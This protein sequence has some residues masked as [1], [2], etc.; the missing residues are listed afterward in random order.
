MAQA[1]IPIAYTATQV[2]ITAGSF[3]AKSGGTIHVVDANGQLTG[4]QYDVG[5]ANVAPTLAVTGGNINTV[6]QSAGGGSYPK[7]Q[8]QGANIAL[9]YAAHNAK[10][11]HVEVATLPA[12]SSLAALVT[13]DW[14]DGT[15]F[16]DA[17]FYIQNHSGAD[18]VFSVSVGT[19]NFAGMAELGNQDV[20]AGFTIPDVTEALVK[21]NS[22]GWVQISIS[23]Q[24]VT[25]GELDTGLAAKANATHSHALADVT[26]AAAVATTGNPAMDGTAALGIATV[27]AR[28]DH[29]HP[30]DTAKQAALISGTNIKT[31]DGQSLIGSGNLAPTILLVTAPIAIRIT[32]AAGAGANYPVKVTIGESAGA[33]GANFNLSA[34]AGTFPAEKNGTCSFLFWDSSGAVPFWIEKITGASP[35]RVAH[36]WLAPLVSLSSGTP[37]VFLTTAATNLVRSNGVGVFTLFDDFD[38]TSLDAAKWDTSVMSGDTYSGSILSFGGGNVARRLKAL[39]T[40]G[41]GFEIMSLLRAS[42][43]S[44][45]YMVF[46]WDSST[47][48]EI[49]KYENGWDG[50]ARINVA[51][52]TTNLTNDINNGAGVRQLMRIARSGGVGRFSSESPAN[53]LNSASGVPTVSIAPVIYYT[54]D[55]Y[56]EIDWVAVKKFVATEPVFLSAVQ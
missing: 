53:T 43:T 49:Y 51:G 34:A 27:A 26:N 15:A 20:S 54:Y 19:G 37:T 12:V 2:E 10:T 7:I 9:T 22:D 50:A 11:V 16:R 55:N 56:T 14:K 21:I 13:S 52:A 3:T 32:S 35:N 24:M 23:S 25:Q 1:I 18:I 40:V 47:V 4:V 46:G 44:A 8:V 41:D 38:G 29:V 36:I 42:D 39:N 30:S 17:M 6:L 45:S 5:A 48:A 31:V 33:T 28:S